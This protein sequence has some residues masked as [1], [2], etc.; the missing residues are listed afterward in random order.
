[1][2]AD[3]AAHVQQFINLRVAGFFDQ[4]DSPYFACSIHT[5]TT[6]L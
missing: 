4:H 5:F 1:M 2:P 3:F 6:T